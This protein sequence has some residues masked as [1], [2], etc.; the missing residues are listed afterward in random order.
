MRQLCFGSEAGRICSSLFKLYSAFIR[1]GKDSWGII[2]SYT[3]RDGK[4]Y[5]PSTVEDRMLVDLLQQ[6]SLH[7]SRV[8]FCFTGRAYTNTTCNLQKDGA[9]RRG[10]GITRP[11]GEQTCS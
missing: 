7:W 9:R 5:I 8:S 3:E 10:A 11:G 6:H 1:I 2:L 4:S